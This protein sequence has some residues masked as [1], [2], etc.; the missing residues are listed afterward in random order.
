MLRRANLGRRQHLVQVTNIPSIFF[1]LTS[2]Q[3]YPILRRCLPSTALAHRSDSPRPHQSGAHATGPNLLEIKDTAQTPKLHPYLPIELLSSLL[4]QSPDDKA[5]LAR[6]RAAPSLLRHLVDRND[7]RK[8][9]EAI[10][11]SP[12][13]HHAIRVLRLGHIVGGEYKQNAYETVAYQLAELNRWDLVLSVVSLGREHTQ[14]TTTRLLN[15]RVRA[16]VELDRHDVLREVLAEFREHQLQPNRRT[17]HLL[18][19]GCIRN[20]DLDGAKALLQK[21]EKAGIPTDASTH[22]IIIRYYRTFGFN[23]TIHEH[24]LQVLPDI[25]EAAAAVI[26]NSLIQLRLDAGDVKG[27]L[28]ILSLFNYTAV[29]PI[30]KI[31][32]GV[33]SRQDGGDSSLPDTMNSKSLLPNAET[34]SIFINYL[35]S[36]REL[37]RAVDVFSAFSS[38]GIMPTAETVTSLIHLL[39]A[40]SQGATALKMVADM[41]KSHSTLY[42]FSSLLPMDSAIEP[43]L[44]T[45]RIAPT[46]RVFNAL[47]KGLLKTSGIDCIEIMLRIMRVNGISPNASTVE[48]LITHLAHSGYNRPSQL[49]RL[50]RKLTYPDIQ[51]SLKHLHAILSAIIRHERFLGFG[52]GWNS[53]AAKFSRKRRESPRYSSQDSPPP[54]PFDP[55]GGIPFSLQ[56]KPILR[57][58]AER[59]IKVDSAAAGLRMKHEAVNKLNVENARDVFKMLLARGLQP[60]A[61][62]FSA[63]IEGYARL[64]ELQAAKDMLKSAADVGVE[65][66]VVMFTILIAGYARQGNPEQA[67][68][69]FQAMVGANIRPDI[70]S[71]DA[72]ASAFFAVGAYL[73]ARR[74]LITLWTYIEPFPEHLRSVTLKQLAIE[75][76]SI[77]SDRRVVQKPLTKAEQV[78]MRRKLVLLLKAWKTF[79]GSG[80]RYTE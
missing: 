65:V 16:L 15:W 35:T 80:R 66:N 8:L 28:E 27:S 29:A 20:R 63:L 74:T 5:A 36:K 56:M 73:M 76:R 44:N 12:A 57:S 18:I 38:Q 59:N 19:S 6:I 10:S 49:V 54:E 7:A 37:S 48:T 23:P 21:M 39:F 45:A 40:S 67:V 30:L 26:L 77:R 32:S 60:N 24:T 17:F 58:L 47:L 14:K 71:I 43:P 62:H 75:F 64:G 31:V 53:I 46:T 42:S 79:S 13:P 52:K 3:P 70:A 25:G 4:S 69:T 1:R 22:V 51:P 41:C 2:F 9:A 61:Y 68:R 78:R 33:V 34:Y 50:L 72:V 55:L 11:H